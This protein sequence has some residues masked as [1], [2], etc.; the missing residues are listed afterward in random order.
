MKLAR[1]RFLS[2]A[3]HL[4]ILK[5]LG[6]YEDYAV[7]ILMENSRLFDNIS[8]VLLRIP[9]FENIMKTDNQFVLSSF[10][11]LFKPVSVLPNKSTT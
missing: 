5:G 1:A 3:W 8:P 4:W 10:I 2:P 9:G 11:V 7:R 6:L